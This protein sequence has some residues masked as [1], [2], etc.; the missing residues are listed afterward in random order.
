MSGQ[1][2]P[3]AVFDSLTTNGRTT[4]LGTWTLS[5][6]GLISDGQVLVNDGTISGGTLAGSITNTAALIGGIIQP[7]RIVA[8]TEGAA[9]TILGLGV[10]GSPQV[11]VVGANLQIVNGQLV[12]TASPPL[13]P[14]AGWNAATNSLSTGGSLSSGGV[15][16]PAG[17]LVTV[18]TA[19]TTNID[20]Q[21]VWNI[22]DVAQEIGGTIWIRVPFNAAFAAITGGSA[23]GLSA[24][25]VGTTAWVAS[26]ASPLI[27]GLVTWARDNSGTISWQR[28]TSGTETF[29]NQ[30]AVTSGI[31][32]PPGAPQGSLSLVKQTSAAPLEYALINAQ[33]V[34]RNDAGEIAYK[35]TNDGYDEF[36]NV[37]VT[38]D[39][40]APNA[41]AGGGVTSQIEIGDPAYGG[42]FDGR[43]AWFLAT[44]SGT[45]LS[46]AWYNGPVAGTIGQSAVTLTISGAGQAGVAMQPGIHEGKPVFIQ[47]AGAGGTDLIDTVASVQGGGSFTIV[48]TLGAIPSGNA[49]VVCPCFTQQDVNKVIRVSSSEPRNYN[50]DIT[51]VATTTQ[52]SSVTG[53]NTFSVA[54][55]TGIVN[56]QILV[57]VTNRSRIPTGTT[58]TISGTTVTTSQVVTCQN[59]DTLSFGTAGQL[60]R[61]TTQT[62]GYQPSMATIAS[63][64]SPTAVVVAFSDKSGVAGFGVGATAQ[65]RRV[66]WFTDNGT[67]LAAAAAAA[68]NQNLDRIHAEDAAAQCGSASLITPGPIWRQWFT[69][70]NDAPEY[71]YNTVFLGDN[72]YGGLH[73]DTGGNPLW[74]TEVPITAPPAPIAPRRFDMA[75]LGGLRALTSATVLRVGASSGQLDAENLSPIWTETSLIME[76]FATTNAATSMSMVNNAIGGSAIADLDN[77]TVFGGLASRYSWYTNPALPWPSYVFG[78]TGAPPQIVSYRFGSNNDGIGYHP[79]HFYSVYW[80]TVA[81]YPSA[82]ITWE[83]VRYQGQGAYN[84][85]Q[86]GPMQAQWYAG[87]VRGACAMLGVPCLDYALMGMRA[88]LGWDDFRRRERSIPQFSAPISPTVPVVIGERGRES[89]FILTIPGGSSAAGWASLGVLSVVIGARPDNRFELRINPTTNMLEWRV[90]EWGYEVTTPCTLSSGGT[91]LVTSGQTSFT[92]LIEWQNTGQIIKLNDPSGPLT[93]GNLGNCIMV[94][95]ADVNNVTQRTFLTHIINSFAAVVVDFSGDAGNPVTLN[96]GTV[97]FGGMMFVP[98]DVS[99]K[100]DVEITDT[101]GNVLRTHASTF[102]NQFEI[103]L[104]DPW[105]HAALSP[106]AP[107]K[108]FVGKRTAWQS[109]GILAGTDPNP[110]ALLQVGWK[111]ERLICRYVLGGGVLGG[112]PPI[113]AMTTVARVVG[114]FTPLIWCSGSGATVSMTSVWVDTHDFSVPL[115]S[116]FL[117]SGGRDG[118]GQFGG[119]E[120]HA[121]STAAEMVLRPVINVNNFRF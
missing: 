74:K 87:H 10:D 27:P 35:Y 12:S 23:T 66:S 78:H 33:I 13:T 14:F 20:G 39:F 21:S 54:S 81:A 24:L 52:A 68:A 97:Q 37:R 26:P 84:N 113:V 31:V 49:N 4:V 19:G 3:Q 55:S 64:A 76:G 30:R 99:A 36:V 121:P 57:D 42:V 53:G 117:L 17:S 61:D 47:G 98:F 94:P 119:S 103:G 8:G 58:V 108:V 114:E 6:T 7:D 9:A 70:L 48:G 16:A 22:G 85:D 91:D 80:K 82:V 50:T 59:G 105:P 71:F 110:G 92:G 101:S 104:Q 69:A 115:G 102:T 67:A 56:G 89:S 90:Q 41:S 93:S 32:T 77:G 44:L 25:G 118:F 106:G 43:D 75:G 63:V 116:E 79:I 2:F 1:K 72:L 100:V 45:S 107:V 120:V 65:P 38:G 5:A 112:E 88:I 46:V 29:F 34:R 40:V 109:S 11:M 18:T 95:N 51:V 96:P 15:G 73:F 60:T 111:G 62:W 83:M 28:D 86:S